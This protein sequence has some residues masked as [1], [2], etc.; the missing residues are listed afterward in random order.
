MA[1]YNAESFIDEAIKSVLSQTYENW[2]LVIVDDGSTDRTADII[3]NYSLLDSR[4]KTIHI[5]HKGSASYARNCALNFASGNYI[6]ILDADDLL[7]EDLLDK[8]A[9]KLKSEMVDIIVPNLIYFSNNKISN[10]L[11]EITPPQTSHE[12][13][14]SGGED[15]FSLSLDWKLH[16]VFAIKE[17]IIKKIQY[18]ASLINGDEF[19]T[20][21]CFYFAEK[22][23]FVDSVYYYRQNLKSTTKNNRNEF[24]MFECLLTRINIYKFSIENRMGKSIQKKCK[25]YLITSFWEYAKKI[26]E[27]EWNKNIEGFC[28]AES[29]FRMAFKLIPFS[30]WNLFPLKKRLIM[31]LSFNNYSLFTFELRVL[32]YLSKLLKKNLLD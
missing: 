19:T 6:Q 8:Y 29:I 12:Q 25:I 4:I 30:L 11:W 14:I 31:Y 23:G 5:E 22:V 32:N 15:A 21:R 16:G 27:Y 26:S 17:S 2:E 24:R 7:K 13:N 18:D 1:A 3:D 20:R 10:I 9:C 28:Y